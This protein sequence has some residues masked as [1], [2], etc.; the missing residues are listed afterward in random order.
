MTLSEA[1]ERAGRAELDL[2]E[3][4]GRATPTVCR[5]MD[6]G[7][8]RY[9]QSKRTRESKKKHKIAERK[10]MKFRPGIDEHD[11]QFKVGY[12][13]KFLEK[14]SKTKITVMFRGRQMAHL[15]IGKAVLDRIV[16]D[17]KDIAEVESRPRVERRDMIMIL[18]PK[19]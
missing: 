17:L 2:V 19:G 13:R 15:D 11:Y 9:Q 6:Y 14:G 10:E 8:Y 16:E 18:T 7:K 4:A 3:V 5:I 12:L 1:L